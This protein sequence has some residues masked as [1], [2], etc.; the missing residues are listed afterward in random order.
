MA[1]GK[2]RY[3]RKSNNPLNRLLR[4]LN[5]KM[6][7]I[8]A[9]IVL[10]LFLLALVL[11]SAGRSP[12]SL[13]TYLQAKNGVAVLDSWI[14]DLNGAFDSLENPVSS[15][16]YSADRQMLVFLSGDDLYYVRH[17][18]NPVLVGKDVSGAFYIS[19]DS[20][21]IVFQTE[22]NLWMYQ[23][24][25]KK[26]KKVAENIYGSEWCISPDGKYVL[27]RAERG[28][29]TQLSL[30]GWGM[31]E[32]PVAQE[33]FPLALSD[34]GKYRYYYLAEDGGFDLYVGQK[35]KNLKIGTIGRQNVYLN[36]D[37]TK[38][39]YV[40]GDDETC[41][42][43]AKK[44]ESQKLANQYVRGFV[45]GNLKETIG[46]SEI[47][48]MTD[49]FKGCVM[50]AGDSLYWIDK[51]YRAVEITSD[52]SRYTLSDDGSAILYTTSE[53]KLRKVSKLNGKM[54]TQDLF[55]KE[56]VV[57][58]FASNDLS[59]I[60]VLTGEK[61]LYYLGNA[62]KQVLICDGQ[63]SL[64]TAVF[65]HADKRIYYLADGVLFS[66]AKKKGSVKVETEEAGT[67]FGQDY[68]GVIYTSRDE[69]ELYYKESG[70]WKLILE[71]E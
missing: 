28:E 63:S 67:L 55:D 1:Q 32:T 21:M 49:D 65:N 31:K 50:I 2:N 41:L 13:Y 16:K 24:K 59:K 20:K 36:S 8:A 27:Y 47:V 68:L 61:N 56:I 7:T 37:G 51:K 60:Y 5:P 46:T 6:G 70:K 40:N 38:I 12:E 57:E 66:A 19:T 42:L 18:L 45:R 22:E 4:G 43:S 10:L 14:F 54:K 39:I 34:K 69:K 11:F 71:A 26:I 3:S 15:A 48:V 30:A 25:N 44:A 35:N 17:D 62:K 29:S 52:Y 33:G 64:E 23:V 58:Y 9:G 53:G